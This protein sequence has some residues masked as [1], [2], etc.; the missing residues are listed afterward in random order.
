[1]RS[2]S[3]SAPKPQGGHL[4]QG[5][6]GAATGAIIAAATT[7]GGKRCARR[8]VG[9]SKGRQNPNAPGAGRGGQG[10]RDG[11]R[12]VLRAALR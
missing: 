7:H 2:A 6:R 5:K 10:L 11:E 9:C 4:D 12:C 3:S 1:L 8:T